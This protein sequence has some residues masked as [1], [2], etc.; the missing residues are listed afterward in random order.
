MT[1]GGTTKTVFSEAGCTAENINKMADIDKTAT[2]IATNGIFTAKA[3]SEGT[4]TPATCKIEV[5]A[6]AGGEFNGRTAK[7]ITCTEGSGCTHPAN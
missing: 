4:T 5:S 7:T 6:T 3:S 1:T 2:T